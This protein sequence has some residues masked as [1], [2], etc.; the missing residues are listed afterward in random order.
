MLKHK[1]RM[2]DCHGK[3]TYTVL[4]MYTDS[5]TMTRILYV[6]HLGIDT[7]DVKSEK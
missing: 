2:N 7:E 5:F 3:N 6:L 1:F 4:Q